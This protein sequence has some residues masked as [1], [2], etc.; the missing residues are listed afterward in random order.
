LDDVQQYRLALHGRG[1]EGHCQTEASVN[2]VILPTVH[3]TLPGNKMGAQP[4]TPI[5]LA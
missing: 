5:L 1:N 3:F 2:E 4:R